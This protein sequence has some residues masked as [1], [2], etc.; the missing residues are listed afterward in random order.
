MNSHTILIIITII[1]ILFVI[2]KTSPLQEPLN[3]KDDKTIRDNFEKTLLFTRI[4]NELKINPDKT[5]KKMNSNT[6]K[7]LKKYLADSY[8]K[9]KPLVS[10][11]IYDKVKKYGM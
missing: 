11:K 7:E 10:N 3:S 5:L 1:I 8:Y 4:I 6:L 2:H 9:G